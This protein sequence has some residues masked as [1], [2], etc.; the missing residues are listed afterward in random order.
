MAMM[1]MTMMSVVV[2]VGV[3]CQSWWRRG[4]KQKREEKYV[5]PVWCDTDL[6][7]CSLCSCVACVRSVGRYVPTHFVCCRLSVMLLP[8][9]M[10]P[11]VVWA[12][13]KTKTTSHQKQ[14]QSKRARLRKKRGVD[15]T[16]GSKWSNKNPRHHGR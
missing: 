2:A 7:S 15:S 13:N 3:S 12:R 10:R 11:S 5:G 8:S 9:V 16:G 4:A 14:D 1:T 6:Y